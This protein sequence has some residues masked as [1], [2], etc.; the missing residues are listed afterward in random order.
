MLGATA[1]S[2]KR[3][4]YLNCLLTPFC[5]LE[6]ATS[7]LEDIATSADGSS[8]LTNG[9]AG[10]SQTAAA[11]VPLPEA[12]SAPA[13]PQEPLPRSIEEFDKLI[14]DDVTAFVTA[15]GKIGGLV[16]EQVRMP[17]IL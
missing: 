9:A 3:Q 14:E 12:P 10:S 6:A 7:R 2:G 1:H 16:E 15:S 11:A 13:P 5:R 4:R 17:L 8:A